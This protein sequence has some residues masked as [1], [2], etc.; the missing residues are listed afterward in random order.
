LLFDR[1]DRD[2]PGKILHGVQ[3]PVTFNHGNPDGI[4]NVVKDIR[5]VPGRL[6]PTVVELIGRV[7]H[8]YILCDVT[9]PRPSLSGSIRKVRFAGQLVLKQIV[10]GHE[11][12]MLVRRTRKP[13][14][15]FQEWQLSF[16]PFA[17]Y[18]IEQQSLRVGNL[19]LG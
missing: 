17:V 10:L 9:E 11:F 14:I 13:L 15:P 4:S 6:H 19:L 7:S 3:F 8:S 1:E 16:R 2:G 18:G 5:A 12:G